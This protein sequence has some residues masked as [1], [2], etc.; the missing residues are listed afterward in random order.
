MG[1]GDHRGL[2]FFDCNK[3]FGIRL[4]LEFIIMIEVGLT[5]ETFYIILHGQKEV[6]KITK[7]FIK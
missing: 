6:V 7:V 5:R 2:L 3:C 4:L 1:I